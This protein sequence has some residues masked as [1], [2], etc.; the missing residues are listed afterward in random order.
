MARRK[1]RNDAPFLKEGVEKEP[2]GQAPAM[3]D[4][5]LND[6]FLLVADDHGHIEESELPEG[7]Q[8]AGEQCLVLPERDKTFRHQGRAAPEAPSAPGGQ[9]DDF[10]AGSIACYTRPMSENDS[11]SELQKKIRELE[12]QLTEAKN[13]LQTS[14]IE[15]EA[16]EGLVRLMMDD[17]RRIYEDLLKSQSQLMQSDKLATIGLLTAGIVHEI[18]NPLAA[19]NLAFS[20]MEN[21]V[22]KFT[23]IQERQIS[24]KSR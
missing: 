9:Q 13:K 16:N 21:Q 8:I 14:G 12:A 23:K 1:K 19:V 22:K 20:L 2:N 7:I 24:P 4:A 3:F 11:A 6:L 5:G 10:H 18:N 17:M 15:L